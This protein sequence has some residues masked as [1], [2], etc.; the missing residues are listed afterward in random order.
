[1]KTCLPSSPPSNMRN[2]SFPLPSRRRRCFA[3]PLAEPQHHQTRPQT[4]FRIVQPACKHTA[5]LWKKASLRLSRASS[6]F[7]HFAAPWDLKAFLARLSPRESLKS[8]SKPDASKMQA[9][10]RTTTYYFVV[11]VPISLFWTDHSY[12]SHCICTQNLG[13]A[14]SIGINYVLAKKCSRASVSS[15][16]HF[17]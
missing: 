4:A 12:L 17:L 7:G 3:S 1:M 15:W 9:K 11:L 13:I 10:M 8:D 16:P 5:A 2:I 14:Q 6:S